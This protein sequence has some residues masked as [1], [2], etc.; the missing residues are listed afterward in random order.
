MQHDFNPLTT[1]CKHCGQFQSGAKPECDGKADE[2]MNI[3]A[4][5]WAVMQS[6]LEDRSV[7]DLGS[8]DDQTLTDIQVEQIK[9]I[10][11]A[12]AGWGAFVSPYQTRA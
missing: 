5:C 7:L 8:V 12:L 2:R 11:A 6:N 10:D 1:L 4:K 9:S 3:A